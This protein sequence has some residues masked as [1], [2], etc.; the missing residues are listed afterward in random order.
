MKKVFNTPFELSL[1]ALFIL[2]KLNQSHISIERLVA[3][4]FLIV[5][6]KDFGISEYNLHGDNDYK[7]S[8]YSSKRT[9]M[10]DAIKCLG[11]RN[12]IDAICTNRGFYFMI[13]DFGRNY[14]SAL[15]NIYKEEYSYILQSVLN[16]TKNYTDREL[17]N[18][19]N[20]YSIISLQGVTK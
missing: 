12:L 20:E 8:E 18:K 1:R 5:Y 14:C 4:D 19:I 9:L 16:K 13:N 11:K 2:N 10:K 3:L 15:N 6:G 17:I 7:Y